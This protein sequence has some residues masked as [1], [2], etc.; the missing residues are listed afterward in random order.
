M[1]IFNV[2]FHTRVWFVLFPV[3]LARLV[4]MTYRYSRHYILPSSKC[5]VEVS[6]KIGSQQNLVVLV[7]HAASMDP[8]SLRLRSA[9][10]FP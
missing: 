2:L 7:A 3:S 10:C 5:A 1:L 4:V 9:I 6:S 8:H